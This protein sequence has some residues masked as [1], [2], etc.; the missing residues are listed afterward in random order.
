MKKSSL[1][2][3]FF[4]P[5]IFIG[6]LVFVLTFAA[7]Q[8]FFKP[9]GYQPLFTIPGATGGLISSDNSVSYPE[10]GAYRGIIVNEPP[11][12]TKT[13]NVSERKIVKNAALDIIVKRIDSSI[14]V[15]KA[16]AYDLGGFVQNVVVSDTENPILYKERYVEPLASSKS[17]Y[18]TIRLPADNLE[19]ALRRIKGEAVKVS[20]ENVSASDVTEQYIDLESQIRNLKRAEEAYLKIL[21]RAEKIEDILNVSQRLADVR[22]QVESI[23]GQINY[24]SRSIEMSVISVSLTSEADVE[25]LGVVWSPIVVIKEALQ[26]MIT[27]VIEYVNAVIRLLFAVPIALLWIATFGVLLLL[28]VKAVEVVKKM[29]FNK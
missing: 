11:A 19:E 28:L 18:I 24:L 17:A 14:A 12:S 8:V 21:D 27:G 29:L 26:R 5:K 6:V 15:I 7:L 22:G 4:N 20:S 3:F 2:N 16:V 1:F 13:I 25:V 10:G 23:Q 9:Q